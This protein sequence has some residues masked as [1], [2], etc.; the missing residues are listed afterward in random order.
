M[1]APPRPSAKPMWNA[2]PKQDEKKKRKE[3][4]KKK[5]KEKGKGQKAK[6][7]SLAGAL[8]LSSTFLSDSASLR[9]DMQQQKDW[10]AP[11]G[12]EPQAQW[13]PPNHMIKRTVEVTAELKPVRKLYSRRILFATHNNLRHKHPPTGPQRTRAQLLTLPCNLTRHSSGRARANA[14]PAPHPMPAGPPTS[15]P[16]PP[17]ASRRLLSFQAALFPSKPSRKRLPASHGRR[18]APALPPPPRGVTLWPAAARSLPDPTCKWNFDPRPAGA[19]ALLDLLFWAGK[20]TSEP[21][22]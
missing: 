4:K 16:A 13:K 12:L 8:V 5:K 22:S 15:A 14:T 2:R 17:A 10:R 7:G 1:G 6:V 21:G 19:L 20:Q 9:E 3:K 18:G 11:A